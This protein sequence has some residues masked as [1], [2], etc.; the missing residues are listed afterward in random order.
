[1]S[2]TSERAA[3]PAAVVVRA[4]EAGDA[5]AW[6]AF[7]EAHPDGSFFHRFAW[8]DAMREGLGH[9]THFLLA[10]RDGAID[11][12]MPLVEMKSLLFGHSLSSMP[13][14]TWGGALAA[15]AATRVALEARAV[16]IARQLGV[17]A[18]ELRLRQAGDGGRP[19]KTLYETFS[20][21]IEADPDANMQAIRSKQ[22][23]IIRKGMKAGLSGAEADLAAFYPVYAESVR[24]LGT[25]VFPR[26]LFAAIHAAFP[27]DTEFFAV[28]HEGQVV[29]AAM[30]FYFRDQVCP[31]YWGGLYSARRIAAN[32]FLAWELINRAGARG[33]RLFDFGRS[34]KDTG[35]YQWKVNLGFESRQLYYEYELIRDQ[36]MPD[37]N[38]N[39]PK[40]RL[41]IEGWKKLPLPLAMLLGPWISRSLG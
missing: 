5:S 18:L 7:V 39:N 22:R 16:E 1:M 8:Q 34:K 32:D 25:P 19:V 13:F 35:A 26:G 31:Y 41:F 30:N 28:R 3:A 20:K 14:A 9:R 4:A 23:N 27:A 40:Y 11:G 17:G 33:C 10:L 38:P 2:E 6:D 12:V 36:A 29:S 21:P 24:N 37:V 15:S